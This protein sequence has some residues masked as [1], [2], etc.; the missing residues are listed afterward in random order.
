MVL[1][2]SIGFK[3]ANIAKAEGEARAIE[4]VEKQLSK[5]RSYIEWYKIN[6]WNGELPTVTAGMPFIDVTPVE[7]SS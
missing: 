7:S 2:S 6:K 4:I 1:G 5:S 3:K